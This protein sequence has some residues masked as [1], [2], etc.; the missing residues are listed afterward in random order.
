MTVKLES[1]VLCILLEVVRV[2]ILAQE[3]VVVEAA[4][5]DIQKAIRNIIEYL[6]L[7]LK[8]LELFIKF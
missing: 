5:T 4:S 2:L 6:I 3:E 1:V 7:F 8:S